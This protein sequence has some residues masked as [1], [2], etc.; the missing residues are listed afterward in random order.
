LHCLC[1][2]SS[3]WAYDNQLICCITKISAQTGD[4]QIVC[5]TGQI[6]AWDCDRQLIYSNIKLVLSFMMSSLSVPGI[7]T[8][9]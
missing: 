2:N 7:V 1:L 8:S 5:S 4:K 3:V 9:N 6:G